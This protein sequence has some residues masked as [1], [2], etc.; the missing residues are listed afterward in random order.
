MPAQPNL[1]ALARRHIRLGWAAV[2][3]FMLLG[4]A[5]EALHALKTDWYLE[6]AYETRRL[7]F[8]LAHAHGALLGLVN[9]AFGLTV[10]GGLSV[11]SP[12]AA[13]R[14][15]AAGSVLLPAGFFLGGLYHYDGDPGLG[16]A[17]APVGAVAV[18]AAAVLAALPAPEK[19]PGGPSD[20][21]A[22]SHE[23]KRRKPR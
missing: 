12:G 9:I 15:L 6:A 16:T 17:L 14:L 18:L 3:V 13:S 7:M 21:G 10:G 19:T 11:R 20:A 22:P 5:L 8:T 2:A 1:D 4:L 23:K